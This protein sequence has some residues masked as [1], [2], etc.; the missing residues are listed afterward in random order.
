M[1][2]QKVTI[3]AGIE[4]ALQRHR[5]GQLDEAERVYKEILA[6]APN[7]ADAMQ[8]LGVVAS[9]K[10]RNDIAIDLIQ[11]A[12]VLQPQTP[13][14]YFN[15]GGIY[16]A[17]GRLE[18]SIAHIKRA[19]ELKPDMPGGYANLGLALS[20][21]GRLDEALEVLNKAM[22]LEP[23]RAV[24]ISTS[25]MF[26]GKWENTKW[27][28]RSS[29]AQSNASR[30][31]PGNHWSCARV[32]LQLGQLKE[33]WEEFEWRL[34]FKEMRLDRGFSQPQWDG[35]D[36]AGKTILLHT[37]GGLG[38]ALN[39]IRLVPL[40]RASGGEDHRSNARQP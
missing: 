5:A 22:E 29:A 18:E 27:L 4:F 39:F 10:G 9:Q 32:L 13:E 30:N 35:S 23:H 6:Q 1:P 25:A 11:R 21:V 33:G 14:L 28:W 20:E 7:C 40:A 34:R 17:V 19:V 24:P 36:P 3:K 26:T 8:L 15:L 31:N 16:R 37:E 12:I 38:D 2:Q